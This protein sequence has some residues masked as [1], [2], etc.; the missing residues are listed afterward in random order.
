[1]KEL[2]FEPDAFTIVRKFISAYSPEEL[3]RFTD[4][5]Y[6]YKVQFRCLPYSE[7][8]E[9]G[10]FSK[11]DRIDIVMQYKLIDEDALIKRL[12]IKREDLY[13]YFN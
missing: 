2:K 7:T 6:A 5:L 1:M 13:I 3:E 4:I 12:G 10:S 11:I 8:S 9:Y